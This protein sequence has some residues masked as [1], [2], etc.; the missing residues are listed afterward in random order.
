MPD[1][2]IIAPVAGLP[3]GPA[4]WD[5]VRAHLSI[6]DSLDDDSLS[7]VINAVNAEVTTWPV[8]VDHL[9]IP[10]PVPEDWEWPH[11]L[12][13]GATLLAARLYR[14]R[15]SPE[16]IAGMG[17]DGAVYVQRNDP[18][19]SMLLKIGNSRRPAVG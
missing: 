12:Q 9:T 3:A 16:G 1:D 4:T 15:N 19:I 8:V 10:D 2:L 17:V 7:M 6:E 14:R 18:D 13:L 5:G 11:P